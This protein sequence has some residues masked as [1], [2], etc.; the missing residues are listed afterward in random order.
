MEVARQ[1]RVLKNRDKRKCFH[2]KGFRNMR[3]RR[4]RITGADSVV[5]VAGSEAVAGLGAVAGGA[6][7][8]AAVAGAVCQCPPAAPGHSPCRLP[9][10]QGGRRAHAAPRAHRAS[11]L[12]EGRS[13]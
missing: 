12:Q 2:R 11:H 7:V 10:G 1:I 3:Y 8:E 5:A 9:H 4:E 6:V 13:A